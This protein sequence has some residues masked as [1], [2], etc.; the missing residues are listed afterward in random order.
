MK[1]CEPCGDWNGEAYERCP[2]RAVRAASFRTVRASPSGNA[3]T[4]LPGWSGRH[5]PGCPW[6]VSHPAV[7]VVLDRSKAVIC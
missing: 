3:C 1:I 5:A 2:A 6:I 4:A 7:R